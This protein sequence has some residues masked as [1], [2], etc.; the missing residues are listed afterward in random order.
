[1]TPKLVKQNRNTSSPAAATAGSSSGSVTSKKA[2]ARLLPSTRAAS[3]SR[4]SRLDQKPPTMR[5]TMVVL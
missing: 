1:M 5:T 3:D 4:V 2:R